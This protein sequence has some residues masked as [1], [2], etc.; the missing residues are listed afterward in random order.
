MRRDARRPLVGR[1]PQASPPIRGGG[2]R[3][4]F[5]FSRVDDALVG[6]RRRRGRHR[7][8]RRRPRAAGRPPAPAPPATFLVISWL[9]VI[10]SLMALSMAAASS[11]LGVLDDLLLRLDLLDDLRAD[12][13]AVLL[14]RLVDL[15]DPAGPP[16]AGLGE[17]DALLVL[18]RARLGVLAHLLDLVLAR[19]D[20]DSI[21]DLLLLARALRPW[22][23]A[24]A[25]AL[26]F[27]LGQGQLDLRQRP[28]GAGGMPSRMKRPRVRLP[29][30]TFRSPCITWTSTCGWLSAAV[31]VSHLRVGIVVLRGIRTCLA[32]DLDAQRERRHV[33]QQQVLQGLDRPRGCGS[34]PRPAP[35][36]RRG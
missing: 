6:Y 9:A 35:R 15:V 4:Y 23:A 20:Q 17:L 27:H 24:A 28:R 8:P 26:A 30:A 32:L 21:L 29:D 25:P 31:E 5:T 16:V 22:R 14:D 33:Q 1:P 18:G 7:S 19:P 3:G 10:S 36:P 34:A 12:L 13:V 11:A 2:V